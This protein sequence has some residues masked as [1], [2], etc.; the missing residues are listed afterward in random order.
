MRNYLFL[1]KDAKSFISYYYGIEEH[2]VY[3]ITEK[4]LDK[5]VISQWSTIGA[6]FG[7]L[8]SSFGLRMKVQLSKMDITMVVILL[9]AV[10]AMVYMRWHIKNTLNSLKGAECYEVSAGELTTIVKQGRNYWKLYR[11][12][13]LGFG[14]FT[15]LYTLFVCYIRSNIITILVCAFVWC[16]F[17]GMIFVIHPV[18]RLS[19]KRCLRA[20]SDE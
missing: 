12:T 8:I 18:N 7:V 3:A 20:I 11:K 15:I 5:N 1:Y 17:W 10:L 16:I 14:I 6:F 13:V 4:A 19:L 9:G 2:S